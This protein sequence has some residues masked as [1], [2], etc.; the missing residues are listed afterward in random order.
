MCGSNDST[1]V[2]EIR[3]LGLEEVERATEAIPAESLDRAVLFV[4]ATR[5]LDCEVIQH[6]LGS[7][8][9]KLPVPDLDVIHTGWNRVAASC[10]SP[11]DKRHGFPL[12]ESTPNTRAFAISLLHQFGRGVLMQRVGDMVEQ[13]FLVAQRTSDGFSF[14]MAEGASS[15]FLDNIEFNQLQHFE[16]T[17]AGSSDSAYK[18]WQLFEHTD[19]ADVEHHPGAFLSRQQDCLKGWLHDDVDSL[20]TPLIR[21]WKTSRGTMMA[22]DAIPEVDNHFLALATTFMDDCRAAT[23]IHPGVRLDSTTGS[24]LVAVAAII[25]SL[26]MKHIRFAV[27]ASQHHKSI[28]IPQS[29]TIWTPEDE[30][31]AG[32][33]DWTGMSKKR[34]ASAIAAVT[35]RASEAHYLAQHTMAQ[36]PLLVSFE[37]DT[38]LRPVASVGR[39]P[40]ITTTNLLVSRAPGIR[41]ALDARREEWLRNDLYA[42]F[43]G[44]RYLCVDGNI[45]LRDGSKT[46][47]DLDAVV[48]DKTAGDLAIF[49]L[50]W[51]DYFTNDVRALRSRSKNLVKQIDTWAEKVSA[52]I[53]ERSVADLGRTMRINPKKHGAI[54]RVF[55]FAISR[56]AAR[57]HGYGYTSEHEGLAIANWPQFLRVRRE[58]GPVDQVFPRIHTALAEEATAT[59]EVEPIPAEWTVAGKMVRFED[60]WNCL[61]ASG[62]SENELR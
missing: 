55:L 26:H 31:T 61:P 46:I 23:G 9:H 48:F 18:G 33:A 22:Y 6:Q 35:L 27:L 44:R 62:G 37:N 21:P 58:I 7:A 34:V 32:I 40:L 11:L 57:V 1:I 50:K 41:D 2:Q 13:G 15:Q 10:L 19:L 29:L 25:A 5:V 56:T 43:Q 38:V 42:L 54:L 12:M 17:L 28:S 47:T 45:R 59:V 49:Q 24:D 53:L 36:V 4:E 30:L 60:L 20:M 3:A 52:W 8:E 51:Q 16:D 14:A 39:N